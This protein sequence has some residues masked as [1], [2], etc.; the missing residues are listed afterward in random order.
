M[1]I[2]VVYAGSRVSKLAK[3]CFRVAAS[4]RS[5]TYLRNE[6]TSEGDAGCLATITHCG[7]EL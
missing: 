5:A 3:R 7:T 1:E 6:N 4:S 2:G